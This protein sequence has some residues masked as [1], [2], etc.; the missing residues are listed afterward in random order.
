MGGCFPTHA[1]G[2]VQGDLNTGFSTHTCKLPPPSTQ[3][4]L[5]SGQNQCEPALGLGVLRGLR[6]ALLPS[7]AALCWGWPA[8]KFRGWVGSKSPQDWRQSLHR[9]FRKDRPTFLSSHKHP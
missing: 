3:Y 8:K 6:A 7:L 5:R 9:L 1:P 2:V 4:M